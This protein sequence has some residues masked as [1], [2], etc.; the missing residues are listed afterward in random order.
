MSRIGQEK[1][2]VELMIR[3]YCRKKDKRRQLC[4]ECEALLLYARERLERCPFGENKTS[5]Q[6]CTIHCYKPEMRER[7][8]RIMR[9]AGPRML[10]YH[11]LAA[12]K[13]LLFQ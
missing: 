9:F 5:C 13:H 1:K 3:V 7:M 10:L 2:T 11:P 4:T 12:L 8:R 6:H